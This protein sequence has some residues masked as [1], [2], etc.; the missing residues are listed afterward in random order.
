MH[1]YLCVHVS[2]SKGKNEEKGESKFFSLCNVSLLFIFRFQEIEEFGNLWDLYTSSE[3]V[4]ATIMQHT[5]THIQG[6]KWEY[7]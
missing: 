1:V 5:H 7:I 6:K 2:T 3:L 4:T